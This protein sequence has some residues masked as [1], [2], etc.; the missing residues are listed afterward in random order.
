MYCILKKLDN[1]IIFANRHFVHSRRR[2]FKTVPLTLFCKDI[3]NEPLH[4]TYLLQVLICPLNRFWKV[5]GKIQ[6]ILKFVQTFSPK[7]IAPC[8]FSYYGPRNI[9]WGVQRFFGKLLVRKYGIISSRPYRNVII[10][11]LEL[12]VVADLIS[13]SFYKYCKHNTLSNKLLSQ[14]PNNV[15]YMYWK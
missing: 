6:T 11:F 5:W 9:F 13:N 8:V 1:W 14:N 12:Y 15:V 2:D 10:H 3:Q 4:G 7:N